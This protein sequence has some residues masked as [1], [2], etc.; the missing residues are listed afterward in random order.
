[1]A[2]DV[3]TVEYNANI[4]KLQQEL[5]QAEQ[6]FKK[7][8]QAATQSA[9]KVS[10]A[11]QKTGGIIENLNAQLQS[12]EKRRDKAMSPQA[13]QVFNKRIDET[14]AKIQALTGQV[15]KGGS[16][17]VNSFRQIASAVGIAFGVNTLV[18]FGKELLDRALDVEEVRL[19]FNK[20]NNA[21][22]LGDLRK[23]VG[24]TV[25]DLN[26][27]KAAVKAEN[28]GIPVNQLAAAFEFAERRAGALGL[29]TEEVIDTIVQGIG[30]KSTR[31]FAA[32]GI[33]ALRVQ[34]ALKGLNA[35]T[36]SVVD[37]SRALGEIFSEEL[38]K[39][40]ESVDS[41][42]DKVERMRAKWQNLK[43]DISLV[44]LEFAVGESGIVK[45]IEAFESHADF[46]RTTTPD[47]QG[48][49]S[50]IGQAV[51]SLNDIES[52]VGKAVTALQGFTLGT[53][54]ATIGSQ[55]K[56]ETAAIDE[57]TKAVDKNAQAYERW[58][59]I[60]K[61]IA[62]EKERQGMIL[63]PADAQIPSPEPAEKLADAVENLRVKL[64]TLQEQAE[65]GNIGAQLL[66]DKIAFEDMV[67]SMKQ[68]ASTLSDISNIYNGLNEIIAE[69]SRQRL[70][71]ELELIERQK[72]SQLGALDRQLENEKLSAKQR[73]SILKQRAAL[74][75]DF[76]KKTEAAREEAAKKQLK[77]TIAG[78][79]LNQ[80]AAIASAIAGAVAQAAGNPIGIAAIL[81][82]TLP[83][84]LTGMAQ[85]MS[86]ANAVE[87]AEGEV[88]IKGPGTTTSDSIPARLSRRESVINAK[89]TALD[90]DLLRAMNKGAAAFEEHIQHTYVWPYMEAMIKAHSKP[91]GRGMTFNDR[92][93][94]KRLDIG[95]KLQIKTTQA[96][97]NALNKKES[98]RRYW[99]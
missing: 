26:L 44:F 3:V 20:L 83:L 12:L 88:D 41:N 46:W 52:A 5:N 15:E 55:T 63:A 21:D 9:G 84:I 48:W 50:A 40:G 80:S 53:A 28:L 7:T 66:E 18:R 32:L 30:A 67:R 70:E 81:A 1:M 8:D 2:L 33:D 58:L 86:A 74:E 64:K 61:E 35:E 90:P 78:I 38:N 57:G 91:E 77:F 6:S 95:N 39:M 60:Q 11:F 19:A 24:G 71:D 22:L 45:T 68:T 96:L 92:N 37:I 47:I 36:A 27:M 65:E 23:A 82:I 69:G 13:I 49:A 4:D 43:D 51:G 62:K 73:E 85:A 59:E 25:A 14:R 79:V 34:T 10:G 72:E 56:K 99:S 16:S 89:G 31:A 87:L 42:S 76:E 94:L 75:E 17:M 54:G 98:K 93:I 97:L 29:S